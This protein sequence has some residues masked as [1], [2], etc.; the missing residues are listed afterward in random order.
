MGLPTPESAEGASVEVVKKVPG[1]NNAAAAQGIRRFWRQAEERPELAQFA[2][3]SR[4]RMSI[5]QG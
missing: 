3:R 1:V 4:E 5:V 2:R